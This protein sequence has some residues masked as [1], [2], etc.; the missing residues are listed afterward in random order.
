M[1]FSVAALCLFGIGVFCPAVIARTRDI[2]QRDIIPA[3]GNCGSQPPA[4]FYGYN[5]TSKQCVEYFYSTCRGNQ[6]AFPRRIECLQRCN[7]D[8]RCLKKREP[9]TNIFKF[10]EYY[11]YD[12]E[13][14]ECKL[15]KD[16]PLK[17]IS[18]KDNLFKS[19]IECQQECMPTL[20]R[21]VYPGRGIY[22]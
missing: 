21:V 5:R 4:I 22:A 16:Y 15:T 1:N 3:I 19:V 12:S 6:N 2:C 17:R 20:V 11:F 9:S 14:N 7:R 8:S 18:K 10:K 13:K